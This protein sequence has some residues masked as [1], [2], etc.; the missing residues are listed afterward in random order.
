MTTKTKKE[1]KSMQVVENFVFK[2]VLRTI[3][4][5]MFVLFVRGRE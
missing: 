5:K 3:P 1:K 4:L 2:I